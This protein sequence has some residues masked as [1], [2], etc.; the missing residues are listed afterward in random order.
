MMASTVATGA[1]LV[2]AG[3]LGGLWLRDRVE[4]GPRARAGA[5][6]SGG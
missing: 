2:L 1:W 4:D 3:I 5:T 6:V